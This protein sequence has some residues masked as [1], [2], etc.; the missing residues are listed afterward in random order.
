MLIP[1]KPAHQLITVVVLLFT[2]LIINTAQATTDA[3]EDWLKEATSIIKQQENK[4]KLATTDN[5]EA[6]SFTEQLKNISQIKSQAQTCISETEGQLLKI[7]V[8]L[9][10]LGEV[11]KKEN[12]E[13]SKKRRSLNKQQKTLDKQLATC[14]LLLLQSQDLTESINDLQQ[15]ILAQQLSAR[16][17]HIIDV[18][19]QNIKQPTAGFQDTINFLS[20]QYQLQPLSKQQLVLLTLIFFVGLTLGIMFK[21]MLRQVISSSTHYEDSVA[22]LTLAVQTSISSAL[23]VLLPVLFTAAFFTIALPFTPLPFI[24]KASYAIAIYLG[25]A[26]SIK[27]ILNPAAPARSYIEHSK[28]QLIKLNW[29]LQAFAIIGL[30]GFFF[31]TGEIKSSFSDAVY[32]LNRSIFSI[33]LIINL[34]LVFWLLRHFPW[35]MLSRKP[36][37]FLIL[38]LI[39]T[40]II[41][42]TGYRNLSTFILGGLLGTI[43]GLVITLII[44]RFLKDLC[45]GLDEGRLYWEIRFRKFLGLAEDSLM[46]G[47]IWIRLIIFAGL[48]GGFIIFAMNIW[49]LDDPWLTIISGYITEGFEIGSLRITPTLLASGLLALVTL[50]GLTR[51]AKNHIIPHGLKHTRLDH[52]AKE[53]ITS[54]IGY[55]GVAIAILVSLSITGVKMQNVALIAGA[56][57]VGIGF[58]L[59]NI[60]NNF[61]SGM[62][63]LFERPIR[64]G[65]W[66]VTGDTEGYVKSINIRS[67]QI[68][69]FDRA[70]V[71]VPNSELITAKVTNWMLRDNFGRIKIPIGVSY[72]SD[73]N[74]VHKILLRISNNH[75]MVVKKHGHLNAP[76]VLFRD[77]GDSALNFELRCFIYDVDQRLNVISELNFSILNDF[78][79]NNIEIPFPQRVL[80]MNKTDES[81]SGILE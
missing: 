27:T 52:G 60:V 74:K 63:L 62:I 9:E 81:D 4:L 61:I 23:P 72:D 73:V 17:P 35:A 56:L 46:P 8:D 48:W 80:T 65:D 49:R 39:G 43:T 42:L 59:Q 54:L 58:G 2:Y 77:F 13:V 31:L 19:E 29:H 68:Q 10:I 26:I 21:R 69:T 5:T 25:V 44:Y 7:I 55:A 37:V 33:A 1:R 3:P 16:T 6:D 67:T 57:S 45:D 51:Y 32:F 64:S 76:K 50:L 24:T 20:T 71:I 12:P 30:I 38:T 53:A 66:I 47:L 78:R 75:P 40:L 15:N 34:I 41:E 79:D 36:R 11:S 18:L 22:V 14:K 28:K 70:D